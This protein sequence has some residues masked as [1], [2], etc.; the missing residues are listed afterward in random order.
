M[1]ENQREDGN[2]L[3]KKKRKKKK[4]IIENTGTENIKIANKLHT[5]AYT[6]RMAPK[7]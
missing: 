5:S 3:K 2:N 6:A 7:N 4:I 1:K